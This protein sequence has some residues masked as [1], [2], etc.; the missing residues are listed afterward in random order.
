LGKGGD[1]PRD[2]DNRRQMVMGLGGGQE[3]GQ[4]LRGGTKKKRGTLCWI[5]KNEVLETKTFQ[6]RGPGEKCRGAAKRKRVRVHYPEW[7]GTKKKGAAGQMGVEELTEARVKQGGKPIK[8]AFRW[9]GTAG[10]EE[11]RNTFL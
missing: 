5:K 6:T 3:N 10:Q 11:K 9:V 8:K 7:W 4:R 1:R 2:R